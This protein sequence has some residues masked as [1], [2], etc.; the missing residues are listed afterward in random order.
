MCGYMSFEEPLNLVMT[1]KK[2]ILLYI[3]FVKILKKNARKIMLT[4]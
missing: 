2:S 1:K 3:V 4:I